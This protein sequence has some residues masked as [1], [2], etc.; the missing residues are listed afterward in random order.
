V[1]ASSGPGAAHRGGDPQARIFRWQ[2]QGPWQALDG[3]L[4]EPLDSMPYAL[5]F[6]GDRLYA[7][8]A[9]GRIYRSPDRGGSWER[10]EIEGDAPSAV[11]ALAPAG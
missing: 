1:S 4:P 11:I 6:G 2:R 3:G 8:L 5:A 10:V 9:D 7:G